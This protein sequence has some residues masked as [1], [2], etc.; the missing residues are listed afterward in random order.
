MIVAIG[1]MVLVYIN[2]MQITNGLN[3]RYQAIL[4]AGAAMRTYK[5]SSLMW[6]VIGITWIFGALS[7]ILFV[8]GA[9]VF[10]RT[11]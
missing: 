11:A 9:A 4:Y 8:V 6:A 2:G 1:V 7:I 5:F 10:I 3:K